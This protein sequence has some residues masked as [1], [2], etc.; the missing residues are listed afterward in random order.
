MQY[1]ASTRDILIQTER[2]D[3]ARAFYE[4]VLGFRIIHDEPAM[5][6][7]ETGAF[8]LF[9]EAAP[10]LGPVLEFEV[11]DVSTMKDRLLAEGCLVVQ[12]NESIPQ[13]YLQDAFGLV[14]NLRK[15]T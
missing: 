14:F 9:I 11:E 7:F 8:R 3:D 5:C 6:G 2:P 1:V 10:K 13:C 12:E 4:G 15:K